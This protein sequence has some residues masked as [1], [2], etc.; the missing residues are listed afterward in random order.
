MVLIKYVTAVLH[1]P[2]LS[3]D[4]IADILMRADQQRLFIRSALMNA[5]HQ[6]SSTPAALLVLADKLEQYYGSIRAMQAIAAKNHDKVD[7]AA[8][9]EWRGR[10]AHS[11]TVS[12][13]VSATEPSPVTSSSALSPSPRTPQQPTFQFAGA[14]ASVSGSPNVGVFQRPLSTLVMFEKMESGG[15][16][17]RPVYPGVL[18]DDWTKDYFDGY[19]KKRPDTAALASSS[20]HVAA[21]SA[22]APAAA[23]QSRRRT[24]QQSNPAPSGNELLPPVAGTPSSTALRRSSSGR[25]TSSSHSRTCRRNSTSSSGVSS[26]STPAHDVQSVMP[27]LSALSLAD[28]SQ[29][30][31]SE[32]QT[33]SSVSATF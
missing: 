28:V 12:T 27:S 15:I 26:A 19:R 6:D 24:R 30:D 4:D 3:V 22:A 10:K 17:L 11:P 13:T 25:S 1:F 7:A 9:F 14:S 16:N 29:S 33:R 32:S 23:S 2:G 20:S 21:P 5:G 18:Y 8:K 31:S